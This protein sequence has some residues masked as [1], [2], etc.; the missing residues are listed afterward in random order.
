M[1]QRTSQADY[2]QRHK[3][4]LKPKYN[5][6]AKAYYRAHYGID[7]IYTQKC[8]MRSRRYQE[9]NKERIAS[10]TREYWHQHRKFVIDKEK[11]N[12]DNRRRNKQKRIDAMLIVGHGQLKCISCGCDRQDM[13]QINHINGGGGKER[14]KKKGNG[15]TIFKDI[16]KKRRSVE[17]LDIRCYMC[18]HLHYAQK[19]WGDI[20]VKI[21]WGVE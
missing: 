4:E 21:I 19:R 7:P 9:Q 3:T 14:V 16:I 15:Q 17:D 8:I 11:L 18:N 10:R 1:P 13:L 12:A 20:P 5:E 2:Y 6:H